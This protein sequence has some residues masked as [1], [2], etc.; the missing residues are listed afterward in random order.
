MLETGTDYIAVKSGRSSKKRRWISVVT[1]G[2]GLILLIFGGGYF[3]YASIARSDLSNLEY[4]GG[5]DQ[6]KMDSGLSAAKFAQLYHGKVLPGL[7]WNDPRWADVQYYDYASVLEGFSPLEP[8]S[9]SHSLKDL[10]PPVRIEI[11]SLSIDS[12]IK[13]LEI[14]E[15]GDVRA[16]ETPKNVVGHIPTT[17]NPGENGTVYLF[18]HL[19]SPLKREGSVFRDLPQIPVLLRQGEKVFLILHNSDETK[20]LYEVTR[21]NV[22]KASS[23]RLD[24]TD[25]PIVTL[26]SC[27]P[28]YVYDHRL[29]VTASLVGIKT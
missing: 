13:A 14:K 15:M 28:K 11:P 24:E 7:Y 18:G 21:T 10:S 6:N 3:A 17:A 29:L 8:L 5:S 25:S 20:F 4:P 16:W 2:L 23:F 22:V 9:G 19:Q 27:V 1:I 26:V 12:S